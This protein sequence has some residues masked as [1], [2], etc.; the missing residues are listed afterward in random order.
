MAVE[1]ET[2]QLAALVA[3]LKQQMEIRDPKDRI[4]PVSSTVPIIVD[5]QDR[6]RLYLFSPVAL[7][8]TLED[9]GTLSV[10][11]N[12]WTDISFATGMRLYA[13]NITALQNVLLHAT[14]SYLPN[15]S[16]AVSNFPSGFNVNNFPATQAVNQTQVAGTGINTANNQVSAGAG[17]Q[18]VGMGLSNGGSSLNLWEAVNAAG[19]PNGGSQMGAVSL[20]TFN[21]TNYDAQRGNLDNITL[22]N[23]SAVSATQT[24]ADQLNVNARGVKITLNVTTI[25]TGSLVTTIQVKDPVSGVYTT[26]LTSAAVTTNTSATYTVYPGITATANVSA[27]DILTRTWRVSVAGANVSTFTVGAMPVL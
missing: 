13:S 26:V 19:S 9:L 15:A 3:L 1:L 20:F 4:V 11:A 14:D 12:T 10:A 22:I 2:A 6:D 5:F 23:A 7:T 24:S 27:S 21:G 8:L 16:T 18:V 25:G 17:S